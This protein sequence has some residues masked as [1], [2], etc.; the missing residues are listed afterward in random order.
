M[1]RILGLCGSLRTASS[2]RALLEVAATLVPD[3]VEFVIHEGFGD[4][5]LFRPDRDETPAPV[6]AFRDALR[7]ADAIFVASP[8]YAHGITGSMKN[9]LDWVVAS[10]EFSGKPVAV[11]NTSFSSHHAHAAL[12]EILKTMDTR[13]IGSASERIPL[14]GSRITREEIAAD[15]MLTGLIRAAL[16]HLLEES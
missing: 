5:P 2:N 13:V 14:P 4:F 8:E 1:K 6:Q 9:A 16:L 10:G 11:P 15:P 3:D 7:A 12:V